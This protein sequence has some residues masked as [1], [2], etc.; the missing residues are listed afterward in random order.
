MQ[1]RELFANFVVRLSNAMDT[2]L[3]LGFAV[4]D[5][6]PGSVAIVMDIR[7]SPRM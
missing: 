7:A 5:L 2:M 4:F 6:D 3:F 1:F